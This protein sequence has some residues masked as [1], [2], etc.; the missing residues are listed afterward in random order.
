M[1]SSRSSVAAEPYI[2]MGILGKTFEGTSV[3]LLQLL[4]GHTEE[5]Q[6]QDEPGLYDHLV[7]PYITSCSKVTLASAIPLINR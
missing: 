5:H 1:Y 6:E 4:V 3:V 2:S 7:P